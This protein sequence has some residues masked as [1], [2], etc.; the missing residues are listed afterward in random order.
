[1]N[2]VTGKAYNCVNSIILS[3]A[4]NEMSSDGDM[5]WATRKQA[6][7]RGW[8]IKSVEKPTRIDIYPMIDKKDKFGHLVKGSNGE[9]AQTRVNYPRL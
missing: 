8:L 5:R 3:I 9:I 4:G 7:S 2:A 1:M 6:T